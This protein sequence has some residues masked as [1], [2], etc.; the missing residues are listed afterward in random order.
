MNRKMYELSIQARGY[1]MIEF[2]IDHC[3]SKYSSI[4]EGHF[5]F[6]F[7][8]KVTQ[9]MQYP[10]CVH[11]FDVYKVVLD[12]KRFILRQLNL[13]KRVLRHFRK[14]KYSLK[15]TVARASEWR[16]SS[17]F[18]DTDALEYQIYEDNTH[19]DLLHCAEYFPWFSKH[20]W[21]GL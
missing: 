21:L 12:D 6:S 16:Y 7:I 18:D 19:S 20:T 2:V 8:H 11:L 17:F 10:F 9:Q 5:L 13:S 1:E 3:C 14:W 15:Q 4:V